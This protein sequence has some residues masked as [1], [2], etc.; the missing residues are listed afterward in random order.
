DGV[1]TINVVNSVFSLN[2][3]STEGGGIHNALTGAVNVTNSVFF[4]NIARGAN[5]TGGGVRNVGGS[6]KVSNSTFLENVAVSGGGI[7]GAATV[8]STIADKGFSV[9]S[10]NFIPDV[11]GAFTS[12]GFNFIAN[13]G[14]A[15]GFNQPTDQTGT[16]AAPL[17]AKF[18]F[19]SIPTN[20]KNELAIPRCSSPIVDKG[21]AVGLSGSLTTDLRGAGFPRTNDDAIKPNATGGDGTDIGA[22]ERGPCPQLT[23]TV[24]TT[25]DG[26]DLN[27]GDSICD[28]NAAAAG[29][30][31]TLRAAVH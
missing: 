3:A 28:S 6:L 15:T 12:E 4:E 27:P 19:F 2:S 23:L 14:T 26:D 29:S 7:S 24:N 16:A 9:D 13:R 20:Y 11:S 17:D 25:G 31:C 10:L 22:F 18:G 30:Q 21:T 8:K 5:A 1:G